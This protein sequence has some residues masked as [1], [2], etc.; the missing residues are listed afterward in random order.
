MTLKEFQNL[1][2]LKQRELADLLGFK[3]STVCKLLNGDRYPSPRAQSV[4]LGKTGGLVTPNDFLS[5][6]KETHQ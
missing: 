2:K 3:Q 4:I 1:R 5:Q 6:F